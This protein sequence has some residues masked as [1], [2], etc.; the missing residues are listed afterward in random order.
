MIPS[1]WG[2]LSKSDS[3]PCARFLLRSFGLIAKGS[4]PDRGPNPFDRLAACLFEELEF[5][6]AE[7]EVTVVKRIGIEGMRFFAPGVTAFVKYEVVLD[8]QGV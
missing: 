4:V 3:I 1:I 2:D 7:R 6:R 8:I 5:F